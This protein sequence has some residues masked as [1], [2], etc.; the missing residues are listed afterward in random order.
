MVMA[1]VTVV[2]AVVVLML[3]AVAVMKVVDG[4][5]G[6]GGLLRLQRNLSTLQGLRLPSLRIKVHK[7]PRL[8]QNLH[9]KST[10][11]ARPDSHR[12]ALPRPFAA[13]AV[14]KTTSRC[15]NAA[16]AEGFLR[17]LK[18]SH[19][20]ESGFTAPQGPQGVAP[21]TKIALQSPQSA[22]PAT[23]SEHV[24]K[25][26]LRTIKV[27]RA[28]ARK[29]HHQ[30]Q[31]CGRRRNESAVSKRCPRQPTRFCEP[32]QSKCASKISR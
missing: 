4:G 3:G 15:Q 6:R 19:V 23:K 17:F 10:K 32:A 1:V 28:P 12:A 21:A 30:V 26:Q 11:S 9:F 16:F 7:A 13:R 24:K 8:P 29:S 18:A 2:M 5:A 14:P 20:Q 31:K 25:S 27:S 22:G